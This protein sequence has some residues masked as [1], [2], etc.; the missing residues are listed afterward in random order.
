MLLMGWNEEVKE[1]SKLGSGT[2][3][4]G[5]TDVGGLGGTG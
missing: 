5:S 4:G 3:T 2:G 1:K